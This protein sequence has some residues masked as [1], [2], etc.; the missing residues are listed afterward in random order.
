MPVHVV[1]GNLSGVSSFLQNNKNSFQLTFRYYASHNIAKTNGSLFLM[2]VI[3]IFFLFFGNVLV[4][5]YGAGSFAFFSVSLHV[6]WV[7]LMLFSFLTF[8]SGLI[9]F[10]MLF[11]REKIISISISCGFHLKLTI[12]YLSSRKPRYV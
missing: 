9:T 7:Q 6:L 5:L 3:F 4:I 2:F 8:L 11:F 12:K 10:A 1:V